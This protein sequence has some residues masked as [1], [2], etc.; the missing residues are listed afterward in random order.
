MSGVAGPR[1]EAGGLGGVTRD[2]TPGKET[3]GRPRTPVRQTVD[4][5]LSG[6]GRST[7]VR[8][9]AFGPHDVGCSAHYPRLLGEQS[10]RRASGAQTD[11]RC[12]TAWPQL[13]NY[14]IAPCSLNRAAWQRYDVHGCL[15]PRFLTAAAVTTWAM[16]NTAISIPLATAA[17]CPDIEV[18]FARGTNESPGIG[19]IGKAFVDALRPKVG[20]NHS[21]CM[22]STTLPAGISPPPPPLVLVV[23]LVN[24]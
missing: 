23:C 1:H 2:Y 20:V 15:T 19:W 11:Q 22:R 9:M 13:L 18:V 7:N 21:R 10:V 6:V 8:C 14:W 4:R 12:S 16:L 24:R 5:E 17:P 3:A